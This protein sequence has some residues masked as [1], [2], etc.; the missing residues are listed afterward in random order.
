MDKSELEQSF[1]FYIDALNLPK[2]VRKWR[3]HSVRRWRFDFAWPDL[4]V[5]VEC[6]GGIWS[7]GR[8]VRG[9]GFEG[10][11]WK[12]STAAVMGWKVLRVTGGMLDR[13]PWAFWNCWVA[14]FR[15]AS[16]YII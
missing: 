16:F 7:R 15:R 6:E 10:D 13:T 3:F 5:A 14:R 12:Y 2:P 11:C 4:K 8:H 9:R 1:L